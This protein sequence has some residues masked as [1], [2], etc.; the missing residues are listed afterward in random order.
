MDIP[1]KLIIGVFAVSAIITVVGIN[2]TIPVAYEIGACTFNKF[3]CDYDIVCTDEIIDECCTPIRVCA[4]Q[5]V[6]DPLDC[7]DDYCYEVGHKC[8]P[9]YDVAASKY[10]CTCE[11]VVDI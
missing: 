1:W 8:I 9:E 10:A 4:G 3:S 5:L 6:D 2:M 7:Y 11:A